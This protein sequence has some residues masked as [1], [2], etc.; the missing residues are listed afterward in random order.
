MKEEEKLYNPHI[1]NLNSDPMLSGKVVHILN[2]GNNS[3]GN[4]KK[5]RESDIAM[6]GP[7]LVYS[8]MLG[9]SKFFFFRESSLFAK[10]SYSYKF[11][12][13]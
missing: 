8:R 4:H 10:K 7:R 12:F 9:D 5:G 2:S 11:N 3:I 13:L 1:F 6:L